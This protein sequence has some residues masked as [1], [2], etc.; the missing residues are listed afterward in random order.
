MTI[1]L[2]PC[3]TLVC[4]GLPK[5]DG[6]LML[7]SVRTKAFVRQVRELINREATKKSCANVI[8][9]LRDET[10]AHNQPL[11]GNDTISSAQAFQSYLDEVDYTGPALHILVFDDALLTS[12]IKQHAC[13][14][15]YPFNPAIPTSSNDPFPDFADVEPIHRN[16]VELA[17]RLREDPSIRVLFLGSTGCGKSFAAKQLAHVVNGD[18]KPFHVVNCATLS[19][20]TVNA[21]LFGT[22]GGVFT[23]SPED[24]FGAF[25]LAGDGTLFLDEIGDLPL[26]AQSRLLTALEDGVFSPVGPQPRRKFPHKATRSDSDANEDA[27]TVSPNTRPIRCSIF[28]GTNRDLQSMVRNGTFRAD[29]FYRISTY[30]LRIPSLSERFHGPKAQDFIYHLRNRLCKQVFFVSKRKNRHGDDSSDTSG[31]HLSDGAFALFQKCCNEWTW[32]GNF[33]DLTALFS[34]L[35]GLSRRENQ[36]GIVSQRT[37]QVAFEA[38]CTMREDETKAQTAVAELP[39]AQL[40]EVKGLPVSDAFCLLDKLTLAAITPYIHDAS[41]C[42][43]AASALYGKPKQGAKLARLL[44]N[45]HLRFDAAVPS[46]LSTI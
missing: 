24:T 43:A 20:G 32:P 23:D 19:E 35:A 3:E 39:E 15:T 13:S 26:E 11:V 17:E 14:L 1:T 41:T 22:N 5:A 36:N 9:V 38:I 4:L 29:L 6:V 18:R 27:A 45:L 25:D 12:E 40:S 7:T 21:T 37:M 33:R 46:H 10:S 44:R 31:L 16:L 28:F 8:W 2:E 42:E 34:R 30:A